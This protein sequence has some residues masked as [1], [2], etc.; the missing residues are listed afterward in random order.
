MMYRCLTDEFNR[1]RVPGRGAEACVT[2]AD[3]VAQ[4][5]L[6]AEV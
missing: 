3:E 2:G 1:R 5:F 4:R 6:R